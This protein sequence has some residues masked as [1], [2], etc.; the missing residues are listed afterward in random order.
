MDLLAYG[1][2]NDERQI[3]DFLN[4]DIAGGQVG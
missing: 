1:N 2:F 3:V 4:E